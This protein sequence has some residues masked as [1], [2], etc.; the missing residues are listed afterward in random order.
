MKT[1]KSSDL[2]FI[3]ISYHQRGWPTKVCFH[4][5]YS[6]NLYQK[7]LLQS[8]LVLSVHNVPDSFA[9]EEYLSELKIAVDKR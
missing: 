4:Q 9:G 2:V 5:S 7:P 3:I 8:F 1:K 6:A